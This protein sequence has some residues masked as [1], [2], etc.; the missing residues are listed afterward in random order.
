MS[1]VKED[2]LSFSYNTVTNTLKRKERKKK[3]MP[4]RTAEGFK[5]GFK[6]NYQASE[7]FSDIVVIQFTSSSFWFCFRVK[8]SGRFMK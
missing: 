2:K 4:E 5:R 1:I 3:E 6:H 7:R 8:E